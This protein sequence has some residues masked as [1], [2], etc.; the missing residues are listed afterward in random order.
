VVAAPRGLR[1]NKEDFCQQRS[2]PPRKMARELL[3]Q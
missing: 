1:I 2:A 3:H